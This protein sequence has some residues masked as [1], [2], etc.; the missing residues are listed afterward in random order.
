MEAVLHSLE[1]IIPMNGYNFCDSET[2]SL[3]LWESLHSNETNSFTP[4]PQTKLHSHLL[5]NVLLAK[6]IKRCF[7]WTWLS[8]VWLKKCWKISRT[9]QWSL[10]HTGWCTRGAANCF[11]SVDASSALKAATI[12]EGRGMLGILLFSANLCG[13]QHSLAVSGGGGIYWGHGINT[14]P[15]HWWG[16]WD[17]FIV[18]F[19]VWESKTRGGN[20]KRN[21]V[22]G[23]TIRLPWP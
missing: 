20:E 2:L 21:G 14:D 9:V 12:T 19:W 8:V 17:A 22:E 5:M 6:D 16:N 1:V 10:F 3:C 11:P 13:N 15:P 7:L 18:H 23:G 4:L